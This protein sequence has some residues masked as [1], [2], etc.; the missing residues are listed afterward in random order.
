MIN[1]VET[2]NNKLVTYDYFLSDKDRER[3]MDMS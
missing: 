3:E 1:L 2:L